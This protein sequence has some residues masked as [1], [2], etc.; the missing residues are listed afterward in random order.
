MLEIMEWGD[1]MLRIS[2]F[3]FIGKC[4]F[5]FDDFLGEECK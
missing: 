4:Y 2:F 1:K 5:L 3:F